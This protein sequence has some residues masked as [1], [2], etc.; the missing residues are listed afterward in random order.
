[1]KNNR[2]TSLAW[3]VFLFASLASQFA[4]ADEDSE[5][6][7]EFQFTIVTQ[8]DASVVKNQAN[9]ST[10]WCFA[11]N[12]FLESELLRMG[13]GKF[14]LSEMFAVRH[15]YPKKSL[16]YV[17]LHGNTTFGP[18]SLSGDLL[19]TLAE[20]GAVP[21]SVYDGKFIGHSKHNH[22]EMDA[23]LT[24]L[25]DAVIANRGKR[26]SPAWRDAVEGVLDAYIGDIPE[27]FA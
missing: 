5:T 27:S 15:I 12:S 23:V 3:A 11:T 24:A 13:K 18:G 26:L 21:E 14:D 9:T 22:Q 20:F 16:N 8:L 6:K 2:F 19:R 7:S 10:C 25:L 1:M 17:Q 4:Y